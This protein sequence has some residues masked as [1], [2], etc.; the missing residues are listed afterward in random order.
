MPP[1]PRDPTLPDEYDSPW[2]DA[3]QAYFEPALALLFP[4]VHS[5]VDWSRGFQFLDKELRKV[6]RGAEA[7]TRAVDTLVRVWRRDLEGDAAECWVLLHVEVQSQAVSDLPLRMWTYQYRIFDRFRKDVVSLAILADDRPAWRPDRYE[8][9]LWGCR[10]LL[11]WPVSKLLGFQQEWERLQHDPNPFAVLVMAHLKT[12]STRK[13]PEDR[14]RWKLM[15]VRELYRRGYS[16]ADVIEL[17]RLLD[18]LMALPPELDQALWAEV[19]AIERGNKMPYVSS[20][21]RFAIE[22]GL[23]Q[24]LNE[25]QC[26]ALRRVI[27]ATLVR[28]FGDAPSDLGA[29]LA[30]IDSVELLEALAMEAGIATSLDAFVGFL[31]EASPLKPD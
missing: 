13:D 21:E 28:K 27:Q 24:G 15:V 6:T 30:R 11:T 1:S 3:L 16:R 4:H 22:R 2:K 31:R 9:E 23:Q 10:K 18:W 7:G 25:G 26:I 29:Q 14:Y 17:F 12:Q 20:V 19:E 5:G 8:A